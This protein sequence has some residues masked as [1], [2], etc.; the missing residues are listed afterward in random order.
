MYE[1]LFY[2]GF[3]DVLAVN[4]RNAHR[5]KCTEGRVLVVLSVLSSDR[6]SFDHVYSRWQNDRS[7]D[8]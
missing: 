8:S 3:E 7:C 2:M 6:E 1:L 4:A 5:D